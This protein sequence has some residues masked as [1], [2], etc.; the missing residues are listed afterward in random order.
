MPV[1]PNNLLPIGGLSQDENDNVRNVQFCH[2][3]AGLDEGKVKRFPNITPD[4][5]RLAPLLV[6]VQAPAF[7]AARYLA[8]V[9]LPK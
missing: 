6:E 7:D 2:R 1:Q 4:D 3:G 5:P 8:A 9:R